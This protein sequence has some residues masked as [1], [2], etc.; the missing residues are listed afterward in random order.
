METIERFHGETVDMP[1]MNRSYIELAASGCPL[2]PAARFPFAKDNLFNVDQPVD[3]VMGWDIVNLCEVPV[4]SIMVLMQRFLWPRSELASFQA[5]SNGLASGNHFLEAVASGLLEVIERDATTAWQLA[6]EKFFT[7]ISLPRVQLDTV[8][9]STVRALLDRFEAAQTVPVLFDCTVDTDV[10]VYM[11][12]LY[13]DKPHGLGAYKGYGAHLD[14]EV[15]MLRALTEAAQ[16]RLVYIAGA[17]DDVFRHKYCLLKHFDLAKHASQ[18]QQISATIDARQRIDESTPSFEGDIQVL[19]EK[20]GRVGLDQ[21]IVCDLTLPE[22]EV[23]VVRVIVPGLEGYMEIPS[24]QQGDR[25]I[26]FIRAIEEGIP[27]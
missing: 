9:Y 12:W 27:Q 25:A 22:F 4:P 18:I 13:D 10:P 1:Q 14:P 6:I 23:S 17:R 20:L 11:A 7:K 5:T 8:E 16:S 26:R 3:W 24:Y 2:I 21:V 15:A 19:I